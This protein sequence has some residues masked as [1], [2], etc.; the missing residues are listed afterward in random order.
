MCIVVLI[1]EQVRDCGVEIGVASVENII[2]GARSDDGNDLN[3]LY[4][5]LI[6]SGT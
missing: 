2:S 5:L 1:A 6:R 4:V 3:S